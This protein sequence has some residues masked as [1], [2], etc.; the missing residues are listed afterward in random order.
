M[1]QCAKA[2]FQKLQ[3]ANQPAITFSVPQFFIFLPFGGKN[4][5]L[6]KPK[7]EETV[8]GPKLFFHRNLITFIG[9]LQSLTWDHRTCN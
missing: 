1:L 6:F 2:N 3:E 5:T 7:N 4:Q 9:P 8:L